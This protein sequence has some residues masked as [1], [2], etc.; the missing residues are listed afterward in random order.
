MPRATDIKRGK[1]I[2]ING[3]PKVIK[4]YE[5]KSPMSRGAVTMYK[6]R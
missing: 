2:D 3:V 5:A 6:V 1:V 4:H